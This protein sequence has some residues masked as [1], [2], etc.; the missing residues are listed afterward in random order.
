M[1]APYT[2]VVF[3][4]ASGNSAV[5]IQCFRQ[6]AENTAVTYLRNLKA[7]RE[8]RKLKQWELAELIGVE[9]PS[10]QRYENGRAPSLA[11]A[12]QLAEAL[13][14]TIGEL[15]DETPFLP[16]GPRLFVKGEVAA[17]IWREA[18]QFEED[19]W[20]V[21]TGRADISAPARERF[22]LRVVGDSMN[23]V[24]PAGTVLDCLVYNGGYLV[25]AG[26]RV[27]VQRVRAD[28]TIETTVKELARDES[29]SEWLVPRSTNLTFQPIRGDRPDE[30]IIRVEIIGVVVGAYLPE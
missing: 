10:V 20:T 8:Q 21:Y 14:V 9:Q 22:G 17:G 11:I 26:K 28:Q 15:I 4:N 27:I 29:G 19:E 7:L 25:P 18:W 12:V 2:A 16:A 23:L 30:G 6:M 1:G 24:Y 5:D 13:G 3:L